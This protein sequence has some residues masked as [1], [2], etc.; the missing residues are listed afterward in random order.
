M[1]YLIIFATLFFATEPLQPTVRDVY[2]SV[3][4][5]GTVLASIDGSL[6]RAEPSSVV[7]QAISGWAVG[8]VYDCTDDSKLQLEKICTPELSTHSFPTDYQ[9]PSTSS[10]TG[11]Q[12]IQ[13]ININTC[14]YSP[15]IR[16]AYYTE[17]TTPWLQGKP[18][19]ASTFRVEYSTQNQVI[20]TS[21]CISE[22]G[23]RSYLHFLSINMRFLTNNKA[24]LNADSS[25]VSPICIPSLYRDTEPP[26]NDVIQLLNAE[27]TSLYNDPPQPDNKNTR[28]PSSNPKDSGYEWLKNV[29][30]RASFRLF[31]SSIFPNHNSYKLTLNA[32][33]L[34]SYTAL[35]WN[36]GP[37]IY[38]PHTP[39][40]L[41]VDT[42]PIDTITEFMRSFWYLAEFGTA[43][44]T[45]LESILGKNKE[46]KSQLDPM[47][48]MGSGNATE[49]SV[50]SL[51][52]QI[53][54]MGTVPPSH[55]LKIQPDKHSTP[56]YKM[57]ML[58]ASDC[59]HTRSF[60]PPTNT[61]VMAIELQLDSS[62]V[63]TL[64]RPIS[65]ILEYRRSSVYSFGGLSIRLIAGDPQVP[66]SRFDSIAYSVQS[67]E[68]ITGKFF[69]A[70]AQ[71]IPGRAWRCPI[72]DLNS[73]DLVVETT[74][75]PCYTSPLAEMLKNEISSFSQLSYA[76]ISYLYQ[77]APSLNRSLPHSSSSN[78]S[79]P[80]LSFLPFELTI[81]PGIVCTSSVLTV[82]SSPA[83]T[84]NCSSYTSAS[85]SVAFNVR[86]VF[87]KGGGTLR[88]YVQ[89]VAYSWPHYTFRSL[90]AL[91]SDGTNTD[92]SSLWF[93]TSPFVSETLQVKLN[94]GSNM[95]KDLPANLLVHYVCGWKNS[96]SDDIADVVD[97]YN[98]RHGHMANAL[99]IFTDEKYRALLSA[100]P[101]GYIA[102]RDMYWNILTWVYDQVFVEAID[103]MTNLSLSF[104]EVLTS[105]ADLRRDYEFT[106]RVLNLPYTDT[107]CTFKYYAHGY[108]EKEALSNYS[109][110]YTY[111]HYKTKTRRIAITELDYSSG[112]YTFTS[113]SMPSPH[114]MDYDC[115]AVVFMPTLFLS[116]RWYTLMDSY[117]AD[118]EVEIYLDFHTNLPEYLVIFVSTIRNVISIDCRMLAVIQ[119]SVRDAAGEMVMISY[120]ISLKNLIGDTSFRHKST[121]ATNG[122]S[123]SFSDDVTLMNIRI[124]SAKPRVIDLTL[125]NESSTEKQNANGDI[126][127]NLPEYTMT[128]PSGTI[129]C[130]P[131]DTN[132]TTWTHEDFDIVVNEKVYTVS[133]SDVHT[134]SSGYTFYR[135]LYAV[136]YSYWD[137]QYSPD[138]EPVNCEHKTYLWKGLNSSLNCVPCLDGSICR[139]NVR[140]SCEF[141]FFTSKNSDSCDRIYPGNYTAITEELAY[142]EPIYHVQHTLDGSGY[143]TTNC[144]PYLFMNKAFCISCLPL[145]H[146]CIPGKEQIPCPRGFRCI[147]GRAIPCINDEYQDEEGQ[148]TCKKGA[149]TLI[150]NINKN[151]TSISYSIVEQEYTAVLPLAIHSMIGDGPNGGC[152]ACPAGHSCRTLESIRG[153]LVQRCSIGEYSMSGLSKCEK[154]PRGDM[155]NAVGDAC[156]Y[157]PLKVRD[158]AT[159]DPNDQLCTPTNCLYTCVN[160]VCVLPD[161]REW[162][163]FVTY[164]GIAIILL[165]LLIISIILLLKYCHQ[166]KIRRRRCNGL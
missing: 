24:S 84:I 134:V 133:S 110:I 145:G 126:N 100:V 122:I 111:T 37:W 41:I 130:A 164:V 76:V 46:I 156:I 124:V 78:T 120:K 4:S 26:N 48:V 20:H 1:H 69:L 88:Y 115:T 63:S 123:I 162:K 43:R 67:E 112:S 3:L 138:E 6:L 47:E 44:I 53:Y 75:A 62:F 13:S 7:E 113:A 131:M 91:F 74:V 23:V 66:G 116:K 8:L 142:Q 139:D 79:V 158:D 61:T 17:S 31:I 92:Q 140:R 155:Q 161:V 57:F 141:G 10:A 25:F 72:C 85:S 28:N 95:Q 33:D 93:S 71:P 114:S 147:R 12:P 159:I 117:N 165:I 153:L 127:G 83:A 38:I 36:G 51:T 99:L 104:K 151:E 73:F 121:N 65:L 52:W 96:S 82:G 163:I 70:M 87:R 9:V 15:P 5:N 55:H 90:L 89:D 154:C 22:E 103:S 45:L 97:V 148:G 56:A 160:D 80:E 27:N 137:E 64:S 136:P 98:S 68:D 50:P 11:K 81:P 109:R 129:L 39:S 60:V 29:P 135:G 19:N 18:L 21:K 59:P 150:C 58:L 102:I 49:F 40:C 77:P 32:T 128:I 2:L 144:P 101:R 106:Y 143:L 118:N 14:T 107:Q 149:S 16:T 86:P 35:Y 146:L 34:F 94:G 54:Q 157:I 119:R 125:Q 152:R 108:T 105:D 166:C 30:A 42:A 132:I